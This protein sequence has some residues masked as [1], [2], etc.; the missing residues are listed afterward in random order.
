MIKKYLNKSKPGVSRINNQ[1]CCLT[2][3]IWCASV[4]KNGLWLC[5]AESVQFKRK[6]NFSTCNNYY[7]GGFHLLPPPPPHPS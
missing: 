2:A 5:H 1:V 7:T 3:V 6:K 4:V